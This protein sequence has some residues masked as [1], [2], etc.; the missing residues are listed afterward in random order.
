[1]GRECAAAA[2]VLHAWTMENAHGGRA[3]DDLSHIQRCGHGTRACNA[4]KHPMNPQ[5]AVMSIHERLQCYAADP[6]R[7]RPLNFGRVRSPQEARDDSCG[8]R[9]MRTCSPSTFE[10]S[11]SAGFAQ[12]PAL[13]PPEPDGVQRRTL[14]PS[15][16]LMKFQAQQGRCI[17]RTPR[18]RATLNW[19]APHGRHD[20][21]C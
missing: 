4:D 9:T 12:Q 16:G 3:W 14:R 17:P 19:C 5:S 10:L 18:N 15:D 13:D 1:M 20:E 7:A 11:T 21:D 6:V 2:A 8:K